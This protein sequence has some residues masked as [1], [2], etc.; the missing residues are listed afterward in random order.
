M[1]QSHPR[2]DKRVKLAYT[3]EVMIHRPV[4]PPLNVGFGELLLLEPSAG[5]YVC[6]HL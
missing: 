4:Q 6:A 3:F 2:N 5:T 1:I